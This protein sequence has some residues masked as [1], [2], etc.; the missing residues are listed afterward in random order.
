MPSFRDDIFGYMLLA[1]LNKEER[2]HQM[3]HYF[4]NLCIF[5]TQFLR[6]FV[7]L[8]VDFIFCQISKMRS[9]EIGAQKAYKAKKKKGE[10][11]NGTREKKKMK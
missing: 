6:S 9:N 11:M 1:R 7:R 10:R 8:F 4:V 2:R 5:C 3:R